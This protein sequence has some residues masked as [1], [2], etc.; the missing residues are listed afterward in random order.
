[1]ITARPIGGGWRLGGNDIQVGR[2]LQDV[3]LSPH[4][5]QGDPPGVFAPTVP[6]R[7]LARKHVNWVI[8][9]LGPDTC[10]LASFARAITSQRAYCGRSQFRIEVDRGC[11]SAS[12]FWQRCRESRAASGPESQ[13]DPG[14]LRADLREEIVRLAAIYLNEI[15]DRVLAA[16]RSGPQ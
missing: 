4:L 7:P 15:R 8:P 16:F 11:A 9:T 2:Q 14:V 13:T 6:Y 5:L 12:P 3:G 10:C 1:M